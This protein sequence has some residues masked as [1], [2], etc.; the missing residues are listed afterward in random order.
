MKTL[1]DFK[2]YTPD[3]TESEKLAIFFLGI[4]K[5]EDLPENWHESIID[6]GTQY[7]KS[8]S[9]HDWYLSQASFAADTMKISYD[10]NGVIRSADVDISMLWPLNQS[11]TEVAVDSLPDGF[12]PD[13]KWI[14]TEGNILPVPVNH[15]TVAEAEKARLMAVANATIV[16]LQDAVKYSMATDA[17]STLLVEWEKYRVLLYRIDTTKAPDIEWPSQPAAS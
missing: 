16:P 3:N 8:S 12:A 5:V 6:D 17:E 14:L 1:T 4:E 15:I 13:G 2:L 9:G 11:V 7:L 10:A